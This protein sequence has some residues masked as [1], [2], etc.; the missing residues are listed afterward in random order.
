MGLIDLAVT[1]KSNAKELFHFIEAWKY[2]YETEVVVGITK[3]SDVGRDGIT[4]AELLFLHEHGIPSRNVPARPAL[5][6]ALKDREVQ[7]KIASLMRR[8][9]AAALLTGNRDACERMYEKAGMLGRDAVKNYIRQGI[10]PPNSPATVARKG[11]STPLI[12]TGSM[13]NS[14]TYEVRKKKG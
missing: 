8:G 3:D 9:M 7:R 1:V 5:K 2:F 14:I 10:P 4:N 12:D 11:S 6:P 13:L